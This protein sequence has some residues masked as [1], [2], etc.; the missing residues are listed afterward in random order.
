MDRPLRVCYIT[1]MQQRA[2][3]SDII[4]VNHHLFFADLAVKDRDFDGVIPES[5]AL[6]VGYLP[7]PG[8]AAFVHASHVYATLL[9]RS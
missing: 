5:S 3:E 6:L 9:T 7:N 1:L 2:R 4:I 8:E